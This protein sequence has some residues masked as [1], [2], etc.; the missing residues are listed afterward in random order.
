MNMGELWW[1]LAAVGAIAFLALV[2]TWVP[3]R[4]VQHDIRRSMRA[5][6]DSET[7]TAADRLKARTDARNSL[8][9][10]ISVLGIAAGLVIT[11]L[12]VS[13]TQESAQQ[14]L[15]V[16]EAQQERD[17]FNA[18]VQDLSSTSRAIRLGGV[19]TLSTLLDSQDFRDAAVAVLAL[20]ASDNAIPGTPGAAALA[21]ANQ[22]DVDA[23]LREGCR[24]SK[25]TG[26]GELVN[27]DGRNLVDMNLRNCDLSRAS[28]RGAHA[29]DLVLI[30][31]E[32]VATQFPGADLTSAEFANAN[33][34]NANLAKTT[35]QGAGLNGANLDEADL[36]GADLSGADLSGAT[37]ELAWADSMTKWPEGFD[38]VEAGVTSVD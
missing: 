6:P 7:P 30:G 16:A 34:F 36:R 33:L 2:V 38:P 19:Y 23:A 29:R 1:V 37:L 20:F 22:P 25:G 13:S 8:L 10:S 21:P 35:L 28:V 5:R 32:L 11:V 27:L 31:A 12:Q 26:F 4:L 9:Q 18:A 15:G 3:D 14:Q 17:R 24:A